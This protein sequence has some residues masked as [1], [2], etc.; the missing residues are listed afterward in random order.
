[1]NTETLTLD[2]VEYEILVLGMED[3][4]EAM[5]EEG[6]LN[7]GTL[8]R[9]AVRIDGRKPERN[10][11]PFRHFARLSQ[12]VNRVNGISAKDEEGNG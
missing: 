4:L 2:G 3:G 11:I 12:A 8:I 9:A 1:M 5:D 6:G 7:M 10:E